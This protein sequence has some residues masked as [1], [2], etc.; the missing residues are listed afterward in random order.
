MAIR[1]RVLLVPWLYFYW[2]FHCKFFFD[3]SLFRDPKIA[4]SP[5]KTPETWLLL[6]L[7]MCELRDAVKDTILNKIHVKRHFLAKNE[8]L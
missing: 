4:C 3:F 5:I 8:N 1:I 6:F 2:Y 7:E